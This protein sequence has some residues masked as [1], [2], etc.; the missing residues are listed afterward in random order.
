MIILFKVFELEN[1]YSVI[2]MPMIPANMFGEKHYIVHSYCFFIFRNAFALSIQKLR[3]V[4]N[5]QLDIPYTFE[6][7][8]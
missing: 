2:W 1:I 5:V 4:S 6:C 8:L 7:D 3:V